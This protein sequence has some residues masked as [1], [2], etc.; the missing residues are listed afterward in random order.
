MAATAVDQIGAVSTA[1]TVTAPA[2]IAPQVPSADRDPYLLSLKISP[3]GS[4]PCGEE[5][6]AS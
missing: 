4:C 2:G 6:T 3:D 1:L 5:A